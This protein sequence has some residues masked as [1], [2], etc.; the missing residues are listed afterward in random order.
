[1]RTDVI[2][3]NEVGLLEL[4]ITIAMLVSRDKLECANVNAECMNLN[5]E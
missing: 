5:T 4:N 3:T 1:M 2:I